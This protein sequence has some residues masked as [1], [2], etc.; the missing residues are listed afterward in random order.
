MNMKLSV[1]AIHVDVEGHMRRVRSDAFWTFAASEWHRLYGPWVPKRTGVLENTVRITP[2][3]VEH[4][5]PYSIYDYNGNF[6]FRRD[7]HPKASRQWDKAAAPTQKPKLV[8]SMQNYVDSGRLG[9]GG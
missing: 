2:G 4:V 6:N 3:Q 5:A 8:D 1:S 9:F 7:L